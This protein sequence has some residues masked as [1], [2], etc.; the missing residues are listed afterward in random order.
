VRRRNPFHERPFEPQTDD[1]ET[2]R[3]AKGSHPQVKMHSDDERL[4]I[5]VCSEIPGR[6]PKHRCHQ[7]PGLWPRTNVRDELLNQ[8]KC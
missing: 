3:E 4:G 2:M 5:F 7:I 1:T 6:T 8:R